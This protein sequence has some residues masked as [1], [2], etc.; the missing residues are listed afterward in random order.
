MEK[1]LLSESIFFRILRGGAPQHAFHRIALARGR[2][3]VDHGF[4][5]SRVTS[6]S[7]SGSTTRLPASPPSIERLTSTPK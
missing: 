6:F 1:T 3:P 4:R 2:Q 7:N 5:D